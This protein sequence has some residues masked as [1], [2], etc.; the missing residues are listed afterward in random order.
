MEQD[1][2]HYDT[3]PNGREPEWSTWVAHNRSRLPK[4]AFAYAEGDDRSKWKLP[5]HWID[6][7]GA[8]WAHRGG[9]WAAIRMVGHTDISEAAKAR[10]RE[11]LMRHR[12]AFQGGDQVKEDVKRILAMFEDDSKPLDLDAVREVIESLSDELAVSSEESG[13]LAAD[14]N[15]ALERISELTVEQAKWMDERKALEA[16]VQSEKEQAAALQE[17]ARD[18]EACLQERKDRMVSEIIGKMEL[19]GFSEAKVARARE[20][21]SKTEFE[22]LDAEYEEVMEVFRERFAV[23]RTSE[24]ASSGDSAFAAM[25]VVRL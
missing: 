2:G 10:A 16:Q 21:L 20:R 22:G 18:L 8:L 1:Q 7:Q 25:E 15:D 6:G 12:R 4:Q 19:C 17:K 3:K 24:P 11:H 9:V 13:R 5:H 14:L 23:P